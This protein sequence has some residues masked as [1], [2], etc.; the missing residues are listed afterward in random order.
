M[1]KAFLEKKK[2]RKKTRNCYL[3]LDCVRGAQFID[4][5]AIFSTFLNFPF[6]YVRA[7]VATAILNLSSLAYRGMYHITSFS[8]EPI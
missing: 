1:Y 2:N 7:W 4:H 6:T 5:E 3:L 8:F